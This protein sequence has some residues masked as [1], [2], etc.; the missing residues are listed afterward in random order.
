MSALALT[1]HAMHFPH[2]WRRLRD[3]AHVTLKWH[4]EGPMGWCK[5]STQE[6]SIRTNLTQTERRSTLAHELVHL[7]RGPAILGYEEQEERIVAEEAA[8]WLIPLEKLADGLVWAFDDEELAD[9][10]WVDLETVQ[11]R[12]VTL[13]AEE[14]ATVNATLDRAEMTF[15]KF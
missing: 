6:V 2:P 8:R 11:I 4:N 14:S 13:T 15:P 3:A 12:L 9:L 10:L 7:E 1:L 5:H